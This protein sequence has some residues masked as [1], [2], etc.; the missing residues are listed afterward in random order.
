MGETSLGKRVLPHLPR[1]PLRAH[2]EL[3]VLDPA[4]RPRS[5]FATRIVILMLNLASGVSTPV[6]I[7]AGSS[8]NAIDVGHDVLGVPRPEVEHPGLRGARPEERRHDRQPSPL[9]VV[10]DDEDPRA[11]ALG[12]FEDP[13]ERSHRGELVLLDLGDERVA[14]PPPRD[15]EL[16]ALRSAE[17]IEGHALEELE[18]HLGVVGGHAISPRFRSRVLTR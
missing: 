13:R 14:A 11:L 15:C 12:V 9:P 6:G 18:D 7:T 2:R 8:P 17:P 3:L 1:D 16:L 5:R 10:E 4:T